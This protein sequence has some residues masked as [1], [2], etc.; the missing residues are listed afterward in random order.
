MERLVASLDN[1]LERQVRASNFPFQPCEMQ[2]MCELQINFEVTVIVS[3]NDVLD[4]ALQAAFN[5]TT[6]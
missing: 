6:L 3:V 1:A 5:V 4:R 2:R